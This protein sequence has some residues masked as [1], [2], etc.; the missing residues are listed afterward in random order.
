MDFDLTEEQRL[1]RDSVDRL[2]A[3][4][5]EFEA[6]KKIM[7]EPDGWSCAVWAQYAELGILG[8]PFEEK[9]G[10]FG[11]GPVETAIVM[12]AFGRG[13]VL[14]P[15]LATVILGAGLVRAAGDEALQAA[16]LPQVAAGKTLLAFAHVERQSR[17]DLADVTATAKRDGDGWVLDGAKSV[18]L[19]GDVADKLFVTARVSGGRRDRDGIGLFMLD[20]NAAGVSR[21]G[22]RTQDNLRAAEVTLA[23]ARAEAALGEPGAALPVVERVVDE[24]IAALCAES[25]GVL[26]SMQEL[27]TEYLK[28][29]KQFGVTIGS[30]QALQHRAV[31]MLVSVEQARSMA[32]F[33]GVMAAETDAAERTRAISAAK[34]QIGRS[35]KHVGEEAVQLHGGI[36]V[37]MEYKVG[38]YFKR[39]TMIDLMF[40]TADEH[41]AKLARMGGLFGQAK[42]A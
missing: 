40:G 31:D 17:Y 20:A 1:L 39:Q 23:G 36:G 22:Y 38:H 25:V 19:H 4:R 29:R 8:L 6:R 28:T 11:G 21:R 5:Y 34:V 10:G 14:E 42:A 16:L 9:H 3:D 18:V 13:L 27:T 37:T 2:I 35:G 41:L 24:A 7:A 33:A 30:F 26:T 15:Y 12:E 32:L